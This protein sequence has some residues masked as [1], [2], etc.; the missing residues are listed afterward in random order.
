MA[1]SYQLARDEFVARCV[2]ESTFTNT[3]LRVS[4]VLP[5][6]HVIL[7]DALTHKRYM[8]KAC[9]FGL[10]KQEDHRVER[11]E[12]RIIEHTKALGFDTPLFSGDP[13]GATVKLRLPSGYSDSWGG[14]GFCVPTR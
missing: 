7:R 1:W 8:E 14:E 12:I 11:L 9:N 10:T 4:D 6:I 2:H 5:H 13:R 3:Q